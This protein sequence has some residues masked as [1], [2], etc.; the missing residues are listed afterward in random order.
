VRLRAWPNCTKVFMS[1]HAM[2]IAA[3]WTRTWAS[4]VDIAARLGIAQRYVFSV[5]SSARFA[6]LI[7]FAAPPK[8]IVPAAPARQFSAP[9]DPSQSPPAPTSPP[10]PE[11]KQTQQRPSILSRIL[12]KLLNAV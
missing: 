10:A 2:R 1:P 9:E 4:P 8:P 11:A 12:R 3:L 7:D 5:Y 6:G